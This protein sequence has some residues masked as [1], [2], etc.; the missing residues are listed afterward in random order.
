MARKTEAGSIGTLEVTIADE[1]F[2][3][4]WEAL[5]EAG[6]R[7]IILYGLKQSLADAGAGKDDKAD[8]ARKR[9]ARIQAG[10]ITAG[11]GFGKRLDPEFKQ[12][13]AILTA[14]LVNGGLVAKAAAVPAMK[15]WGD[16]ER[17]CEA[18]GVDVAKLRAK[19]KEAAAAEAKRNAAAT[20]LLAG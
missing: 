16:V 8:E 4:D 14:A 15:G 18:H 12:A 3:V 2:K 17:V 11:G 6:K 20:D 9:L 19:A 5:P 7:Y 13:R 1:T 10:S